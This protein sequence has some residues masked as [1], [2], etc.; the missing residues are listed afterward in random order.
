MSIS[1]DRPTPRRRRVAPPLG[2]PMVPSTPPVQGVAPYAQPAVAAAAPTR[3]EAVPSTS[4]R[5]APVEE[6]PAKAAEN[7]VGETGRDVADLLASF[8]APKSGS[9]ATVAT[10]LRT[11]PAAR[12]QFLELAAISGRSQREVFELIVADFYRRL[13]SG[14]VD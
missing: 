5:I 10:Y 1:D 3:P 13:K 12:E 9:E 7:R 14:S 8:A 4:D 6:M 2:D 11:S